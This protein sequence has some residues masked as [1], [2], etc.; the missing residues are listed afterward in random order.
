MRQIQ[1]EINTHLNV[2]HINL[3]RNYDSAI[4]YFEAI[5]TMMAI[6]SRTSWH[7]TSPLGINPDLHHALLGRELGGGAAYPGKICDPGWGFGV[8]GGVKGSFVSLD[9]GAVWDMMVV[10]SI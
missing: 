3:N 8:S 2:L 10:R 4:D 5:D 9:N 7:Y 1:S 6:Y